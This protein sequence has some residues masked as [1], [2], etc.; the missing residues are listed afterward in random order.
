MR[1]FL[2]PALLTPLLIASA[3]LTPASRLHAQE[4]SYP[5]QY[6]VGTGDGY[7]W[8]NGWDS[9][10]PDVWTGE[11]W[12]QDYASG[13]VIDGTAAF[14]P[15]LV[16]WSS[17]C[18]A[19]IYRWVQKFGQCWSGATAAIIAGCALKGP[20]IAA[21]AASKEPFATTGCAAKASEDVRQA[22]CRTRNTANCG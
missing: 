15:G 1:R 20:G 2:L 22:R 12:F 8:F 3:L 18:D 21:C 7:I 5:S 19:D 13:E 6:G 17:C 11:V 16:P 9:G 10:D 4:E 14:G